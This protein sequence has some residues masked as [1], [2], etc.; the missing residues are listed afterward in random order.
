MRYIVI[1]LL[2]ANIKTTA[3]DL[4]ETVDY[5]NNILKIN[6]SRMGEQVGL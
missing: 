5:I 4:N 1:L 3:Q 2:A 6:H